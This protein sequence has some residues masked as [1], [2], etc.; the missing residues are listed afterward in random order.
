MYR[1]MDRTRM[2][3]GTGLTRSAIQNALRRLAER[4]V[5]ERTYD[6]SDPG[7]TRVYYRLILHV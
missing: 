6:E 2:D 7:R 3:D 5:I 1:D 4:K